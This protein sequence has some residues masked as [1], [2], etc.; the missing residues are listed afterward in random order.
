MFEIEP[1]FEIGF[2]DLMV[3]RSAPGEIYVWQHIVWQQIVM[4]TLLRVATYCVAPALF[5]R[6]HFE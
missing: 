4:L 3:G 5:I 1:M 6:Q 2:A